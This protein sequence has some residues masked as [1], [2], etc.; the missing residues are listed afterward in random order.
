[1]YAASV[2]AHQ[3]SGWKIDTLPEII[4]VDHNRVWRK[5]CGPGR[6][7]LQVYVSCC[8]HVQLS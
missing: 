2:E 6:D 7:Q 5:V 8:P 4:R 3:A 1:M